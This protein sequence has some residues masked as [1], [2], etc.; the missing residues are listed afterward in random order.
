MK[1]MLAVIGS[2]ILALSLAFLF[3]FL[4][5]G[6]VAGLVAAATTASDTIG[7]LGFGLIPI[8]V[9]VGIL[10]A[11]GW[12]QVATYRK[13]RKGGKKSGSRVAYA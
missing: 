10:A 2:V 8:I 3:S 5:S 1:D 6:Y 12:T 4:P 7:E 13:L 11:S 9:Y